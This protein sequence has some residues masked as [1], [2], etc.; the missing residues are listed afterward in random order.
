MNAEAKA[1]LCCTLAVLVAALAGCGR[2]HTISV[3]PEGIAW[4]EPVKGLQAGITERG[5]VTEPVPG[6]ALELHLRNAGEKAVRILRLS[7]ADDYWPPLP[8]EVTAEGVLHRYRGPVLDPP[9]PPPAGAFIDL[10]S[11]ETDSTRVVMEPKYWRLE[12]ALGA[13]ITFVFREMSAETIAF[14]FNPETRSLA[15]VTG[16]WTGQVRSGAV[17]VKLED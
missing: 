4:G 15:K 10:R 13:E 6:V 14:P 12:G 11:G 7:T 1:A 2:K 17:R 5:L 16:L 9:P 8:I 3:E